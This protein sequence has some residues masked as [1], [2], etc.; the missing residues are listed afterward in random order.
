MNDVNIVP[1]KKEQLQAVLDLMAMARKFMAAS[2]NEGQWGSNYPDEGIL[3]ADL[4]SG[5]GRVL[6]DEDGKVAGYFAIYDEEEDYQKIE[7]GRGAWLDN[8]PY[9][10]VHRIAVRT[11]TGFGKK[12]MQYLTSH[13]PNIRIDTKD[14][15]V[16]MR[17]L[18]EMFGFVYVG[19]IRIR[20]NNTLRMAFHFRADHEIPR[21]PRQ[22]DRRAAIGS[23]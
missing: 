18:L 12:I 20:R 10:C 5:R 22:R 4:T 9:I 14:S 8:E 7:G 16:P 6:L 13:Y 3:N 2:G 11:G 1:F 19:N 23:L 21:C 15:N 17:R